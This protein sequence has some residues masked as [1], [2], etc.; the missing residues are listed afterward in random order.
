MSEVKLESSSGV[1]A[2]MMS[3]IEGKGGEKGNEGTTVYCCYNTGDNR[4]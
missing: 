1:Y 4:N 3:S 2:N